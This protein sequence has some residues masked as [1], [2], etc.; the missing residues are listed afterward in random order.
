MPSIGT[1]QHFVSVDYQCTFGG[2]TIAGGKVAF[3][4][5]GG[6]VFT[7][8]FET[9]RT[10]PDPQL[11]LWDVSHDYS[12]F[13]QDT[14]EAVITSKLTGICALLGELLSVPLAQ[15]QQS[16]TIARVWTFA[17]D[18]QGAAAP[19]QLGSSGS[20][21]ITEVMPYPVTPSDTEAASA[22]DAGEA[23]VPQ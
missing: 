16:V 1:G 5:P 19:Q 9:G 4:N 20:C 23:I 2:I 6:T 17:L 14:E 22:A 11:D 8:S 18:T 21:T 15:V 3:A 10:Q 7:F 13:D 12:L